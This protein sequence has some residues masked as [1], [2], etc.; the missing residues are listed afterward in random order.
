MRGRFLVF[1]V[2]ALTMVSGTL[3]LQGWRAALF[4]LV[5]VILAGV[6]LFAVS[7]LAARKNERD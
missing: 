5:G 4:V 3:L 2:I 6:A 7:R 1:A